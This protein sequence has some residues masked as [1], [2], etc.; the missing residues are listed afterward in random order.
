MTRGRLFVIAA[1]SGTGK[2]SLV[3]ALVARRPG[4]SVSVSYTTRSMRAN[5]QDGQDYH[6]VSVAQFRQLIERGELLEYAQ[7]FDNF[8]GTPRALLEEQLAAGRHVLLEIDWQGAQQ[9]RTRM[10]ECTTI[11]ILPPS[12]GA[13]EARLRARGTDSDEVIARRLREAAGELSHWTEFTYAV[14]NDS[15]EQA[16][17]EL[18]RIV[19]GHGEDLDP[20]RPALQLVLERLE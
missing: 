15:F 10:P 5:E 6:F 19:D 9:V 12:L 17:S 16:V 18:V 3:K 13:L 14:V 1:P 7:V 20:A 11:F 2:T 8:Y 4:L